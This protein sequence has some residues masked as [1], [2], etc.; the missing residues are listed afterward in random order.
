MN[1]PGNLQENFYSLTPERVLDAVEQTGLKCTGRVL[2][3]NS[4]ENRVFEVEIELDLLPKEFPR[5]M[6]SNS[7]V[8]AKF[9]R[10]ARWS[11]AQ[12]LEEHEFLKDLEQAEIPVRGPLTFSGETLFECQHTHICFSLFL[13]AG[14]RHADEFNDESLEVLGRLLARLHAVGASKPALHRLHLTPAIFGQANLDY[15]LQSPGLPASIR[16]AYAQQVTAI[17]DLIN[18][19]FADLTLQRIHG[20]AHAANLLI[21]KDGYT[22]VDFDD[23]C[24]GPCV[25]DLWLLLPGRDQETLIQRDIVIEAYESMRS[26][27]HQTLRLIEPLRALRFIHY[28]AWIARRWT[29]RSFQIAFPFFGTQVY[30]DEQLALLAEQHELIADQ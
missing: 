7:Y 6:F 2:Q 15:L 29:D 5:E 4:M 13:K 19:W 24:M 18:P 21:G 12:I 23:F 11:K 3:L 16:D 27:P 30:W 22:W 8:I 28:S 20:D 25:Q 14:G 26:F 17:L 9:Y 10:P 1:N